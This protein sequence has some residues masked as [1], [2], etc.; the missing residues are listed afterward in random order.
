M[1]PPQRPSW[2]LETS[3]PCSAVRAESRTACPRIFLLSVDAGVARSVRSAVPEHPV[4]RIDCLTVVHDIDHETRL[5]IDPRPVLSCC[6]QRLGTWKHR[7]RP[8]QVVFLS[9]PASPAVLLELPLA[10]PGTVARIDEL[11]RVLRED[12]LSTAARSAWAARWQITSREGR[13]EQARCFLE[14]AS[15][16][17][18]E[19]FTVSQMAETLCTG[20]R[21][22]NRL[23]EEWFGYPPG[24]VIGLVRVMSVVWEISTTSQPLKVIA[25]AH[26]FRGKNA[27]AQQVRRFMAL[28]PRDYRDQPSITGVSEKR[29]SMSETRRRFPG[30]NGV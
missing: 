7:L 13:P 19:Q 28:L 10:F 14:T 22:L 5:I 26:R 11:D 6:L 8:R 2:Q 23:S 29:E 4:G 1:M 16:H 17:D 20:P 9:L 15:A 21:Q 18:H 24:V 3:V 30:R 25:A 27:M 12:S